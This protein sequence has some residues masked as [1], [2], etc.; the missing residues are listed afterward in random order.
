[1]SKK[2]A[3]DKT[4]FWNSKAGQQFAK[5]LTEAFGGALATVV[6]RILP[7]QPQAT[8]TPGSVDEVLNNFRRATS[9]NSTQQASPYKV[10]GV[11]PEACQEVIKV[12]WK[13]L[14][15]KYNT[16]T[17]KEPDLAKEKLI[18]NA[19]EQI[20]KDNGWPK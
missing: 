3:D 18:N 6:E 9:A 10:L 1:M 19:Y 13:A 16:D 4:D 17:G 8:I 5:G 7:A 2:Q 12:A 11:D 20:C 15:K 14:R